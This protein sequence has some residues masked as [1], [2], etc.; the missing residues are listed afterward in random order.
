MA[1]FYEQFYAELRNNGA[2]KVSHFSLLTPVPAVVTDTK[3]SRIS[4]IL[5]LRCEATELPGRQLSA[6]DVKIYGP[7]YKVPH[8]SS[9]QEITLTFLET[10]GFIIRDFFERWMGGIWSELNNVLR[11]PN[12]YR[13]DMTLKQHGAT[14]LGEEGLPTIAE[15]QLVNAF[16]TAVNQ[17]PVSW[18]DDGL[19]R[20]AVTIA[21]DY[22]LLFMSGTGPRKVTDTETV[23]PRIAQMKVN[24]GPTQGEM[25]ANRAEKDALTA[26][27]ARLRAGISTGETG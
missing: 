9:Y 14:H 16:P 26:E 18:A 4:E 1:G 17:M 12:S 5:S 23:S 22:Y 8:Q 24:E 15:W 10:Q 7:S 11:Y 19:H 27:G 25:D 2:S 13:V 6:Q 3:F 21:Y 20:L